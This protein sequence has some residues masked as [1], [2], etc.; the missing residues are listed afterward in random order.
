MLVENNAGKELREAP[1]PRVLLELD[2][3]VVVG[4]DN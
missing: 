1:E 3:A 2:E 4:I